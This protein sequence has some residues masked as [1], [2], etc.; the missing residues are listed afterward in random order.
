MFSFFC[1][2]CKSYPIYFF[3]LGRGEPLLIASLPGGGR[4]RRKG[5]RERGRGRGGG[6]EGGNFII[7]GR[8]FSQSDGGGGR[9]FS[10]SLSQFSV[11]EGKTW[12]NYQLPFFFFPPEAKKKA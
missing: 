1:S 6:G 4:G 2:N 12:Q 3:F 10:L 8:N 7:F 5:V 11:S 9:T